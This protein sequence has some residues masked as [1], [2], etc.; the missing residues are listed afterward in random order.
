MWGQLAL[1]PVFRV[2]TLPLHLTSSHWHF[3]SPFS[4]M[5]FLL[6]HPKNSQK[7]TRDDREKQ[8]ASFGTHVFHRMAQVRPTLRNI[9]SQISIIYTM[10]PH[11]PFSSAFPFVSPPRV[12]RLSPSYRGN[13]QTCAVFALFRGLQLLP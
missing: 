4:G 9:N 11:F 13:T 10:L 2:P 12:Q 5:V 6:L 8:I 7:I 1:L 3:S